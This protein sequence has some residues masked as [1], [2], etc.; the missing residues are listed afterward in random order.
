[1]LESL[2]HQY[3]SF[4]TLTYDEKNCP[5]DSSLCPEHTRNWL[6]RL[7]RSLENQGRQIRYFL[8]GEYG[9]TTQRPHYHA[10]LFG[11]SEQETDL[12]GS[13]WPYGFVYPGTLTPESAGY[14]A[15]YVTKKMTQ[16]TDPRLGGRYP[17][18]ARMSLKPGIGAL[19]VEGFAEMLT[20][21]HGA[22]SITETGDVPASYRAFGRNQPIGRYMRRKLR[23]YLDFETIGGQPKNEEIRALE[24]QALL[25]DSGLSS[26]MFKE[27]KPFIAH[28]KI[29]QIEGKHKIFSQ[30]KKL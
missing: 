27:I 2:S 22:E 15:G 21:E 5:H 30:G 19:S 17:E 26:R 3:S 16:K 8:V 18:F 9:D 4:W 29:K 10:A 14:V 7:R 20:T 6:K 28:Q 23:E 1:M 11:I 13:V 24:M 12:V 25:E